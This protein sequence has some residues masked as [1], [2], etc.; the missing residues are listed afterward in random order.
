MESAFFFK[1]LGD[2]L[3]SVNLDFGFVV[4]S[5]EFLALSPGLGAVLAAMAAA[6]ELFIPKAATVPSQLLVPVN[7]CKEAATALLLGLRVGR[8]CEEARTVA[9]GGWGAGTGERSKVITAAV[10][11]FYTMLTEMFRANSYLE[12]V[13]DVFHRVG[14]RTIGLTRALSGATQGFE[15]RRW[16]RNVPSPSIARRDKT[17]AQTFHK[18]LSSAV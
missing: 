7:A 11:K 17:N 3:L 14:A 12:G 4:E 6:A 15:G 1:A 8:S 16:L 13:A 10:R 18:S 2:T 5:A 9:S